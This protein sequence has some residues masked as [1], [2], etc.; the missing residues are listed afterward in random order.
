MTDKMKGV[1]AQLKTYTKDG[2]EIDSEIVFKPS[3]DWYIDEL[4]DYLGAISYRDIGDVIDEFGLDVAERVV[5]GEI[6]PV[7]KE[8]RPGIRL[9]SC[10][11]REFTKQ[12][13]PIVHPWPGARKEYLISFLP[14]KL[15]GD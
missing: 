1:I 10:A 15:P 2:K 8:A 14:E 3:C 13:S 5:S 7:E 11:N 9:V 4:N 6:V 12:T